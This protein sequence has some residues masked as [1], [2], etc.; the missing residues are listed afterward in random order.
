MSEAPVDRDVLLS[1]LQ[2]RVLKTTTWD[3][4][5]ALRSRLRLCNDCTVTRDGSLEQRGRLARGVRVHFDWR[6]E[7]TLAIPI[8][9]EVAY[10]LARA[11]ESIVVAVAL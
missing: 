10:V 2:L 1:L 11:L 9:G 6:T 5:N 8:L 4:L 7:A 3:L